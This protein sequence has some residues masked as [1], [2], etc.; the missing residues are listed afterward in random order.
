[1]WGKRIVVAAIKGNFNIWLKKNGWS[2]FTDRAS[3]RIQKEIDCVEEDDLNSEQRLVDFKIEMT[4]I[5][6][7]QDFTVV[8]EPDLTAQDE[9]EINFTPD[10]DDVCIQDR[11][12]EDTELN[13]YTLIPRTTHLTHPKTLNSLKI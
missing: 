2:D 8:N 7:I 13:D 6:L 1:M 5:A 12:E 3:I 4:Q 10:E 11:Y 9:I